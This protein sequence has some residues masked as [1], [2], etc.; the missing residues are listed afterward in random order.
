MQFPAKIEM[1]EALAWVLSEKFGNDA[2]PYGIYAGIAAY[3]LDE[4]EK[5]YRV[6]SYS[7]VAG[8]GYL[9][10]LQFPIYETGNLPNHEK[11]FAWNFSYTLI[12]N[13]LNDNKTLPDLLKL[14]KEDLNDYLQSKYGVTLPN[15]S[16][17]P[18]SCAYEYR[19]EQGIFTYYINKQFLD[20]ILP[21][22]V[23]SATYN[24]LSEWLKDNWTWKEDSDKQFNV[25]GMYNINVYVDDG[26]NSA[27]S[28]YANNAGQI[29]SIDIYSVG[30][31]SHE[32]IH[33]ILFY[34]GN[35]GYLNEVLP[36]LQANNSKYS[37]LMWYHLFS[38]N[39]PYQ[40]DQ[41]TDEKEKYQ[42]A[43]ELYNLQSA[44]PASAGNFNFWLFA[45]CFAAIFTK[46]ERLLSAV[47]SL[48]VW[49]ISLRKN[50]VQNIF[51]KSTQTTL[52]M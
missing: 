11:T 42:K 24:H 33:H 14:T 27:I 32:Y 6:V 22:N 20:A 43:M 50:M 25:H 18:E 36:E 12:K 47:Y 3:W 44:I 51:G 9:T 26:Q 35:A 52:M 17:F 34:K 15:Y 16:F 7:Q 5:Q 23:F 21:E 49:P 30:S 31:F 13:W 2:L 28:G 10:E 19:V 8:A 29:K 41:E 37:N 38:G 39:S 4:T 45:D 46:K 48:I 1:D 40:Y